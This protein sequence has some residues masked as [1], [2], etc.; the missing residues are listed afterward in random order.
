[1]KREGCG[2]KRLV[3]LMVL[4]LTF[5]SLLA[6]CSGGNEKA[7]K[8]NDSILTV[9]TT[10]YPLQYFTERI[11]GEYVQAQ[12]IY[13]PGA[14][15]HTF[16]PSQKDIIKLAEADLFVYIGLGLEGFA[17][18]SQQSLKNEEVVLLAAGEQINFENEN[19]ALHEDE[20]GHGDHHEQA[21][22]DGHEEI[23][24]HDGHH[25]HGDIDPHVW[26]DP[27]YSKQL[28]EAIKDELIKQ[29]PE[30]AA[31]F[32]KNYKSLIEELDQLDQSFKNLV[33]SVQNKQFI[34]SHAAY[35]YWEKRYGLQQINVSGISSSSEPSQKQLAN[36]IEIAQEHNLKYIFF[37][38][39]ISSKLT[40]II[41][42]A[43]NGEALTLHNLSVLTDEDLKNNRDY[44]SIM[45]DNL[46]ALEKGLN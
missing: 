37:E 36:I 2:L 1:M 14:D 30:K 43:I 8:T 31:A 11:G 39:N 4:F 16:E 18:R 13:P 42:D 38:Q 45:E 17:E 41:Q 44:F 6:G 5:S 40:K 21:N 15:E 29:M 9:Y 32:E 33:D 10:V 34:V 35:G 26:L 27:I 28:A 23:D 12:T 19:E 20:E 7:T 24:E 46:K 3:S 25:H 22:H